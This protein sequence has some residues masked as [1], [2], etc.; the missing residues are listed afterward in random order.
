MEYVIYWML[1]GFLTYILAIVHKVKDGQDILIE[2]VAVSVLAILLGPV[3]MF[4]CLFILYDNYKG[5]VLF[6]GRK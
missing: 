4:L 5:T 2:D 3:I 6:R 1:S